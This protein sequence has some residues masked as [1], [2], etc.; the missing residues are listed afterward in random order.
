MLPVAEFFRSVG[1]RK[2]LDTMLRSGPHRL[3]LAKLAEHPHGIDLGPLRQRFPERLYT[4]DRSIHLAPEPYLSDLKRL[5][6][7]E[8][9]RRPSLALIGRRELRSNNSWMHNSLRLVKG[10]K[11]CTLLM[12]PTD[13]ATRGLVDGE[14]VRLSS[15]AGAVTVVLEVSEEVAPGVVSLPHGWGH[16]RVGAVME[17]AAAHAGVSINDVTDD[18]HLDA[19]TANAAFSGVE[20]EV[21]QE[22]MA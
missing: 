18:K 14:R 19:L 6:A 22:T 17:V 4:R 16:D 13:A 7:F 20:V 21:A 3:S 15:A 1:P 10:P 11:R 12:H 8:A 2:V 5:A 9:Q